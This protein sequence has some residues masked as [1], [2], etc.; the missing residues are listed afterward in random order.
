MRESLVFLVNFSKP[1][2]YRSTNQSINR[3]S[4]C[5]WESNGDVG[6]L[7]TRIHT[8][9]VPLSNRLTSSTAA[10]LLV[11][12]DLNEAKRVSERLLVDFGLPA[13]REEEEKMQ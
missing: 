13:L 7:S 12:S 5:T 1:I 2:F 10:A 6:F 9:D 3:F 11:T 8:D 4:S